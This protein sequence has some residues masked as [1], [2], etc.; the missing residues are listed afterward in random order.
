MKQYVYL[1]TGSD[2]KLIY[3]NDEDE[4]GNIIYSIDHQLNPPIENKTNYK[5]LLITEETEL[6]NGKEISKL[7]YEYDDQNRIIRQ[8]RLMNHELIEEVRTEYIGN[9]TI[10]T[11]TDG[12]LV[13]ERSVHVENE[14]GTR[15]TEFSEF[16]ELF[17]I[18]LE[19]YDAANRIYT[20][21]V[22][23]GENELVSTIIQQVDEKDRIITDHKYDQQ[24]KL[25][26]ETKYNRDGDLVTQYSFFDHYEN[27]GEIQ[28]IHFD[29]FENEIEIVVENNQG[30]KVA[31]HSNI[32]NDE[33]LLTESKGIRSPK[34][35]SV[36]PQFLHPSITDYHLIF[37]YKN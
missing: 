8:K 23:N 1:M 16:G 6:E 32:F 26:A 17:E 11:R 27:K 13:I 2:K 9:K 35:S 20:V 18:Q 14:D 24:G 3:M 33:G 7:I 30:S 22:Y 10:T 29:E 12:I 34:H 25:V 19:T 31:F 4:F 36:A 15:R 37:E 5:G 21:V 28:T